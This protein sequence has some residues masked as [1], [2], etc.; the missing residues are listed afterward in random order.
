MTSQFEEILEA[1]G[2]IFHLDLKIDQHHACSIAIEN[3]ITLQ[4]QPDMAQENLFIFAKLIEIPPGKFRENVL[5]EA[6]KANALPDP[7]I[8]SFGYIAPT[9]H[10]ALFQKIPINLLGSEQLAAFIGAFIE[11]G[12]RWKKAIASGLAA[13]LPQNPESR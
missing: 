7:R 3:Q 6:L 2:K 9:N 8:G 1:L 12:T 11:L 13:P 4:L 10:L 5:K